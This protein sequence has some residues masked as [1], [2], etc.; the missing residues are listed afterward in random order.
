MLKGLREWSWQ[1]P[2]V[3][4]WQFVVFEGDCLNVIIK[5]SVLNWESVLIFN[6]F[7]K[8]EFQGLLL[9][10]KLEDGH[11]FFDPSGIVFSAAYASNFCEDL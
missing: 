8:N 3:E 5:N 2:K 4:G 9:L 7:L 6:F 10:I 11:T 1:H